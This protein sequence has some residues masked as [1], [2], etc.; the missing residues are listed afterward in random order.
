MAEIRLGVV[1]A[2]G[3]MGKALIREIAAAKGARL[4]GGIEQPGSKFIGRD[5]GELAGLGSLGVAVSG[6]AAALCAASDAI[7]DFSAPSATV[8]IAKQ[9][10]KSCTVHVVGTTGLEEVDF[11]AL[12]RA[13]RDTAI[14]RAA[15]MSVGVN[16]L[17]E[18]TREVA[19]RLGPEF[20]IEIV[21]MH[22]RM[23]V[24]AP[25]GTALAL[26]EAAA[27]GRGVK[28]AKMSERG[29]DGITGARKT[30]AIGFAALRGGNVAGDHTVIFAGDDE[31]IELTH[32][33]TDRAIFAR[34]AVR[35]ALWGV[36][37]P[38]GYYGMADVLGFKR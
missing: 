2:A 37:K 38:P 1:G 20:D 19:E 8:S 25:S 21:E 13:A 3:R 24:D 18:L 27:E 15:N 22:H 5:L 31:R 17:I 23:K 6:N 9:A 4:S 7:L 36:G 35:A 32:K 33:A 14:I 34:G 12:K 10:A 16:L 29:R 28:L 30:G 26:G 11:K